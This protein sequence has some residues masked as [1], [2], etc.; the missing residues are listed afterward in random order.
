MKTATGFEPEITS[1]QITDSKTRAGFEPEADSTR[2]TD[3]D[4]KPQSNSIFKKATKQ[5]FDRYFQSS[6]FNCIFKKSRFSI[7]NNCK[8]KFYIKRG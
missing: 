3:S 7:C 4:V 1:S 8:L 6:C 5:I 2:I